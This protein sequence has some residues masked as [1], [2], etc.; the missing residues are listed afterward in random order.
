MSNIHNFII[1]SKEEK[2]HKGIDTASISL[3]TMALELERCISSSSVSWF[4][5]RQG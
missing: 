1:L 4:Q 5:R 3:I 2:V